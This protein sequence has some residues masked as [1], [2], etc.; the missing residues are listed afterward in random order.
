MYIVVKGNLII[1]KA[2]SEQQAECIIKMEKARAEKRGYDTRNYKYGEIVSEEEIDRK[3][4]WYCRQTVVK[5][6]NNETVTYRGSLYRK[7]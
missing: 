2:F 4:G 6:D 1:C 5:F 7:D 3:C